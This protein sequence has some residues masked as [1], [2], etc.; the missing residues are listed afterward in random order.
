[1]DSNLHGGG[2]GFQRGEPLDGLFPALTTH[3]RFGH[4]RRTDS[5][6]RRITENPATVVL[7]ELNASYARRLAVGHAGYGAADRGRNA[8]GATTGAAFHYSQPRIQYTSMP[9]YSFTIERLAASTW[10][11][12]CQNEKVVSSG[13]VIWGGEPAAMASTSCLR[14]TPMA[15]GRCSAEVTSRTRSRFISLS[16]WAV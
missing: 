7:V 14:N 13:T 11:L 8:A 6:S 12:G 1:G 10:A 3:G 16:S 9:T 4:E 5:G 2:G 15:R